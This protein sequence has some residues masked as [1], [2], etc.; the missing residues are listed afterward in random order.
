MIEELENQTTNRYMND[1]EQG[2]YDALNEIIEIIDE[3][4]D[5]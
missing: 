1:L 4:Y 5:L 3:D 2:R